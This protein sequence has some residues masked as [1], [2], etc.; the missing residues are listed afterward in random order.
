MR[1][2]ITPIEVDNIVNVFKKNKGLSSF[3]D[4][5]FSDVILEAA[6]KG[7]SHCEI[8]LDIFQILPIPMNDDEIQKLKDIK[9]KYDITYS[10]HFPIWSI[11]LASPNKFI[12]NASVES[13]VSSYKILKELKS[14]IELYV[15]HPTGAFVAEILKAN[16]ENKY[17]NIICNIFKNFAISSIKKLIQET[18]IDKNKIAIENIE[19]PFEETI[20]IIKKLKGPNL[21]IDTAH[22]L[23]G[24]SGNVDLIEITKKYLDITSEI[25]LQDYSDEGEAD[26][27]ALGKGKKFPPEFLK[28]INDYNFKGPIVFELTFEQA[29]ESIQYIKD[30]YPEIK[31]PRIKG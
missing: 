13:L 5:H 15:I 22:F 30:K 21:C 28:I 24:Y 9:K 19:F 16:I 25:H 26:H 12:R 11:E 3:L 14:Q 1:I 27:A 4:F 7:Y 31:L 20:D 18:K 2:G 23:G 17:K 10:A 29:R 6:E 8:T